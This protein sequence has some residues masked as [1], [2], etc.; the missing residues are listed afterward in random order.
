MEIIKYKKGEKDYL[1]KCK[2]GNS[3][4]YGS[5]EKVTA[6]R[7]ER[8]KNV[9]YYNKIRELDYLSAKQYYEDKRL[10]EDNYTGD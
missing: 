1:Y 7:D 6:W 8:L 4:L 9:E 3:T 5:L 2:I 10:N